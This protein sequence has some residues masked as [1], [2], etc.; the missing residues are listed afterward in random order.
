MKI[1]GEFHSKGRDVSSAA[2]NQL[3]PR[4][5]RS[6][7]EAKKDLPYW[8]QSEHQPTDI[9]MSDFQLPELGDKKFLISVI[10]SHQ[11]VV[12]CLAAF[13][14]LIRYNTKLLTVVLLYSGGFGCCIEF[15]DPILSS[16]FLQGSLSGY[17]QCAGPDQGKCLTPHRPCPYENRGAWEMDEVPQCQ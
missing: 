16:L 17:M 13:G 11:F 9:L 4:M 5:V 6:Q 12:L 7:E 14:K 2:S 1:Q 10:L 15:L 8:F 3:M